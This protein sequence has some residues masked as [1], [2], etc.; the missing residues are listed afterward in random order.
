VSEDD[1]EAEGMKYQR[2][3][4]EQAW[5]E[6]GIKRHGVNDVTAMGQNKR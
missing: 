4:S 1:V 3:N 2:E 5:R 6:G